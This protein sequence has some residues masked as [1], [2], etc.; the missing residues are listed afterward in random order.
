LTLPLP[1]HASNSS[2]DPINRNLTPHLEPVPYQ[3]SAQPLSPTSTARVERKESLGNDD[4]PPLTTVIHRD[5]RES[6]S[7]SPDQ[8]SFVSA[9]DPSSSSSDVLAV[10][11]STAHHKKVASK[12][13][14]SLCAD[15]LVNIDVIGRGQTGKVVKAL[16]LPSLGV[17]ALKTMNAYDESLRHQ[18]I[19]ELVAFSKLSSPYIIAFL[20]SFFDSGEIVL[21]SEYMDWGSLHAFVRR[22]G[23]L[24]ESVIRHI[25]RQ[26]IAGLH[27]LHS[28]FLVRRFGFPV[29]LYFC[30]HLLFSFFFS[31]PPR[32]QA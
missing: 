2:S 8:T 21:A 9:S 32:Y 10:P 11:P 26:I 25:L 15:D 16:H 17:V 13:D 3:V 28:S 6:S 29:V 22:E 30:F 23:P 5:S 14:I 7:A 20:G 4:S 12:L 1:T 31:G 27:H 18:L 24:S 19:K